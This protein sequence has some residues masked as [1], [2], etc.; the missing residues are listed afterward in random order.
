M[1]VKGMPQK[2]FRY[3]IETETE[4]IELQ[5]DP[6]GWDGHEVGFQRSDDFGLNV[7][8]VVP[9]SFSG[10]SRI[11][12]PDILAHCSLNSGCGYLKIVTA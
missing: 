3:F 12:Q 1:S 8:N 4:D 9:L 10:I 11:W 5:T 2:R 6:K 7:E